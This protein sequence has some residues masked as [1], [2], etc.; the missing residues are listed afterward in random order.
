MN[1]FGAVIPAKAGVTTLQFYM[2]LPWPEQ[3]G[4]ATA[5]ENMAYRIMR[6]FDLRSRPSYGSTETVS[7]LPI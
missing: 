5:A 4:G 7:R 3:P 1:G 2:R 6:L